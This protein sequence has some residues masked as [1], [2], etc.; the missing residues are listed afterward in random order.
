MLICNTEMKATVCMRLDKSQTTGESINM[1]TSTVVL[2]D[3]SL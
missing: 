3:T 2:I 1:I